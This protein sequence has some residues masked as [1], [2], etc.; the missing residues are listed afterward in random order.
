MT[1]VTLALFP[2]C[3]VDGVGP[4]QG[5]KGLVLARLRTVCILPLNQNNP[6]ADTDGR[7]RGTEDRLARCRRVCDSAAT[8][9][10]VEYYNSDSVTSGN[11]GMK[12]AVIDDRRKPLLVRSLSLVQR[13]ASHSRHMPELARRRC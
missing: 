5:K 1:E 4:A 10:R 9:N 12:C 11:T 2:K 7:S 6:T 8:R 13:K 3:A